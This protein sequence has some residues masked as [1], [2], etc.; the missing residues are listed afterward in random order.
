MEFKYS[1]TESFTARQIL[2]KWF[3]D[4]PAGSLVSFQTKASTA[5]GQV[6]VTTGTYQKVSGRFVLI[7]GAD[8]FPQDGGLFPD[9]LIAQ[10]TFTDMSFKVLRVGGA[11]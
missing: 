4:L 8:M 7:N 11:A 10:P 3:R 6:V 1:T 9:E 5:P 2:D